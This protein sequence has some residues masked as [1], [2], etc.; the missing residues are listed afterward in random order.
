MNSRR[1]N[2]LTV[3]DLTIFAMLGAL[4]YA[5]K[6]L[7]EVLPNIHF[8]ASIIIAMT[9]VYGKRALYPLYLF[10]LLTGL[11]NGFAPWWVPYLYIWTVLWAV[12]MALPKNLS[13]KKSVIIYSVVACLHGLLYGILYAPFQAL[14]YGLGFEGMIAWIVAGFPF[15]ITHGISN[16]FCGLLIM[17][18]VELLQRAE[19]IAKRT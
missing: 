18:L 6:V 11:L 13:K 8:I 7:M 14:F 1:K 17:P 10:V 2:K 15:D 12:V 9:V 5:S 19:K 4:M 3:K 16:F